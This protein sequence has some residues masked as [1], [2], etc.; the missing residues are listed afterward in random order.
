MSGQRVPGKVFASLA[1]VAH[2]IIVTSASYKGQEPARVREEI[3]AVVGE[4]PVLLAIEPQQALR[5]ARAIQRPGDVIILTGS[6]YMIEQALN[7][8]PYLR[9]LSA[10]FG[11]RTQEPSEATGTLQIQLPSFIGPTL[12]T[13]KQ[14]YE[15]R[16]RIGLG[17]HGAVFA[18]KSRA[19]VKTA[20]LTDSGPSWTVV[21]ADG[22]VAGGI[23]SV[24]ED[25]GFMPNAELL[26]LGGARDMRAVVVRPRNFV[27]GNKLP[28]LVSVYGGPHS[29]TV[30]SVKRLMG[31]SVRDAAPDLPFLSYGVVAGERD[32]ARVRVPL[33]DGTAYIG[34]DGGT[35]GRP[36]YP[37]QSRL[38]RPLRGMADLAAL[39]RPTVHDDAGLP[40]ELPTGC[41]AARPGGWG[42]VGDDRADVRET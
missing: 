42:D 26:H 9:H 4:T 29:Q 8:D 38:C 33:A 16:Q 31:R 12:T 30:S 3:Q 13:G 15:L 35:Q 34:N 32:T 7:P 39:R 41:T 2:T 18:E 20:T 1:S 21:R 11:W 6:T 14:R 36:D 40:L 19:M 28:V 22:S 23:R 5:T 17:S 24:A 25:P 27:K 37:R 10:H